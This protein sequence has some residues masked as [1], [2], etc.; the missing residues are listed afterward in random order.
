MN[1]ERGRFFITLSMRKVSGYIAFTLLLFL[2]IGKGIYISS[3]DYTETLLS[4][5]WAGVII[6]LLIAL[7]LFN[8]YL[9]YIEKDIK[10]EKSK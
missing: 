3:E 1:C 4:D 6:G 7:F 5:F 10:R 8:F 9:G 2:F